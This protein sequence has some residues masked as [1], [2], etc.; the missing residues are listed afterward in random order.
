VEA[1]WSR[2]QPESIPTGRCLARTTSWGE[3]IGT[4]SSGTNACPADSVV[5]P[6]LTT[7]NA[8]RSYRYKD[9][10]LYAQDS[11]RFTPRLTLNY[12]LRYEHYGVQHNNHPNLDS[13]SISVRAAVLSSRFEPVESRLRIRVRLGNSGS[14]VGAPS[15]RALGS[16]M[17]SSATARAVCAAVSASATNATSAT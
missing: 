5:T 14:R 7:A 12:G 17:I 2:L 1:N 9:W 8:A 11:W 13:N 3:P 16:P 15:H 4:T 10:A 6:P